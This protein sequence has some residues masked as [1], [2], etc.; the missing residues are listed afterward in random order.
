MSKSF[1][2]KLMTPCPFPAKGT[3]A[4]IIAWVIKDQARNNAWWKM[5][6]W[7]QTAFWT[8]LFTTGKVWLGWFPLP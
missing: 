2:T 5:A 4:D 1:M 7:I 6:F 3:K 8:I